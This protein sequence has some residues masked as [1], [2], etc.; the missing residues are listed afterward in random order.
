M[1]FIAT[2]HD[3]T[4]LLQAR[5]EAEAA[6]EAKGA[7]LATMSHEIRT[8]MN[9]V[10]GMS[11]L[12][13]NTALNDEQ[14]KY[15]EIVRQSSDTL[16]TVINDILD[17]SKIESGH[18]ALESVDFSLV[19]TVEEA[20]AMFAQPAEA[21]GLELA[22]QFVPHDAPLALRGDPLRLRQV[23]SNLIGN[24][25]KFTERGRIE[26]AVTCA[27]QTDTRAVLH[28]TVALAIAYL[29]TGSIGIASALALIEPMAN[30]VAFFLHE[31]AWSRITLRLTGGDTRLA[32]TSK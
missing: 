31:R 4:E 12:L 28:F 19:D 1:G 2:Y 9:A 14:R 13:L 6:N 23:L 16:L 3:I 30:T 18:L 27:E 26:L 11:G 29:L 20:V 15:A 5:R 8:P 10:I 32:N 25:I 17:F 7:F 21:K 24:A 22:V